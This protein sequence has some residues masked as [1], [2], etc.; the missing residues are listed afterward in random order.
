MSEYI[1]KLTE[2]QSLLNEVNVPTVLEIDFS[3]LNE[4]SQSLLNEVNVPT[5]VS[6]VK[7]ITIKG[8][9]PF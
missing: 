3:N 9:N 4:S 8:R 1:G 5:K 6:D 7:S 2:S